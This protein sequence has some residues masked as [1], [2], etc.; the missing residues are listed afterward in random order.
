MLFEIEM[1][2]AI[3]FK[4]KTKKKEQTI[5]TQTKPNKTKHIIISARDTQNI[6]LFRII[7][8]KTNLNESIR[9]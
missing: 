3:H 9:E 7:S 1:D 6:D 2:Y 4:F 8:T 5:Y